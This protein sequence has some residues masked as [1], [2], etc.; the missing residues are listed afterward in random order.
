MP[1]T[2]RRSVLRLKNRGET[3]WVAWVAPIINAFPSSLKKESPSDI[4][5]SRPRLGAIF[6][7]AVAGFACE[8]F[9]RFELLAFAKS[10]DCSVCGIFLTPGDDA[11]ALDTFGASVVG[12]SL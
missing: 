2:K 10:A 4:S 12:R 8:G 3:V 7:F 11:A 6:T 1:S 5:K 9:W